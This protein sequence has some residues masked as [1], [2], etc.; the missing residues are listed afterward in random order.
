MN[1]GIFNPFF[2]AAPP[3]LSHSEIHFVQ[4]PVIFPPSN[5]IYSQG[6]HL[7]SREALIRSDPIQVRPGLSPHYQ[8]PPPYA[9]YPPSSPA[10]AAA[11]PGF[12]MG[13]PQVLMAPISNNVP[14]P[15]PYNT[16]LGPR[17]RVVDSELLLKKNNSINRQLDTAQ[18]ELQRLQHYDL[19]HSRPNSEPETDPPPHP[20]ADANPPSTVT[21]TKSS[22]PSLMNALHSEV[23]PPPPQPTRHPSPSRRN[24]RPQHS[25][26]AHVKK[27]QDE[28]ET[29]IH[30]N[31]DA[32]DGIVS[33][34]YDRLQAVHGLWKGIMQTH[35]Q[36]AEQHPQLQEDALIFN[37]AMRGLDTTLKKH[38]FPY[39]YVNQALV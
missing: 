8:L 24:R 26:Y 37:Q 5:V 25:L 28:K 18:V 3:Q 30:E 6:P 15:S 1:F 17:V 9:I 13:S 12:H 21:H 27:L 10:Q 20:S 32:T 19:F 11:Y 35:T 34:L 7:Q 22:P 2:H 16:H 23:P 31:D 33:S 4:H 38:R 39:E 14:A 36:V 29:L